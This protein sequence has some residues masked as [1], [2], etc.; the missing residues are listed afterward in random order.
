MTSTQ[1]YELQEVRNNNM[2]SE[3]REHVIE[4]CIS[5]ISGCIE[6]CV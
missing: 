2:N 1:H 6:S 4:L 3:I 5:I